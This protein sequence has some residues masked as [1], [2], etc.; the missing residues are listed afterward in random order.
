M[1][2][3]ATQ[4][5]PATMPAPMPTPPPQTPSAL[6]DSLN[7]TLYNAPELGASPGLAVGV[8][9][10]GGDPTLRA[11]VI[12][13]AA[14]ATSDT[15]AAVAVNNSSGGVLGSALNWLGNSVTHAVGDVAHVAKTAF[16][17]VAKPAM[18]L[19]NAPLN[20]VQ[21]EY[22]YLHD[23]EASHGML[24][25]VAEGIGIAAVS[26][27]VGVAT[28]GAGLGALS[29]AGGAG[30][31]M[32]AAGSLAGQAFYKDSWDRTTNGATYTDPH[33]HQPVSL[34]R[35]IASVLG[36][37]PGTEV[38][39][40]TSGAIDGI[41]DMGVNIPGLGILRDVHS[42][43][44]AGGALGKVFQGYG[45]MDGEKVQHAFDEG[46]SVGLTSPFKRAMQDVAGKNAAE[47]VASPY[48]SKLP[49]VIVN[50]LA[51]ASTAEEA[52][53]V[54]KDAGTAQE[55]AFVDRLPT[56]S[57]TRAYVSQ[58]LREAA[59]N[60]SMD[61][62]LGQN[63]IVGPGRWFHRLSPIA[64]SLDE[65][66][67]ASMEELDPMSSDAVKAVYQT[68]LYT[69]NRRTALDIAN[70]FNDMPEV[71]QRVIAWRNLQMRTLMN[72][73]DMRMTGVVGNEAEQ[74]HTLLKN[75]FTDPTQ[76]DRAMKELNGF[77]DQGMFGKDAIYG[78][79]D[80][81]KNVSLIR[82]RASGTW[83]Y[84]AAVTD[85]QTGSVSM[86]DL[87]QARRVGRALHN[88]DSIFSAADKAD[89]ATVVGKLR[90]QIAAGDYAGRIDDIGYR[91]I[92]Q[93]IFK[94]LVLLTPSYAMHI[95]LAEMIPNALR[96]GVVH[97]AKDALAVNAAKLGI[98]EGDLH[99]SDEALAK[100]TANRDSSLVK[101]PDAVAGLAWRMVTRS[102]D[103]LPDRITNNLTERLQYAVRYIE[104]QGGE[105]I[106]PALQSGHSLSDIT[107]NR[108]ETATRVLR[109]AVDRSPMS[110]DGTYIP[111][112][113]THKNF[114]D[115]WGK[116]LNAH[117]IKDAGSQHAAGILLSE[118]HAGKNLAEAS[119]TAARMTADWIRRKAIDDPVWDQ[120]YIRNNEDM[121]SFAPGIDRP[122]EWDAA[123]EFAEV[124]V[125]ALR[126]I[127]RGQDGTIHEALLE[128]V[129]E[130][131]PVTHY[132]LDAIDPAQRPR[133]VPGTEMIPSG[134]SRIQRI[135]NVGFVK[136]LNPMVNFLSRQSFA[137]EEY[138]TQMKQMES[139]VDK[140][141]VTA[142][143]ADVLAR[144]KAAV[145]GVRFIHNLTDRTQWT[146]TMR[147]WAPFFFAQEQAY[148]RMGRLLAEDPVAFR[149]YQLMIANVG[150][151]GQVFSQPGGSPYFVMPHTGWFNTG[152]RVLGALSVLQ[153]PLV[154]SSPVGLG[155]NLNASS[156]IFPLSAGARPDL[157]PLVGIPTQ[158][159]ANFFAEHA[160]PVLASQITG[161][162]NIALGATASS[163]V[164][165][166]FVP[167][168][169]LDRLLTAAVPAFNERSF[170]SAFMQTLQTLDFQG[171]IPPA[172][173]SPWVMQAFLD[174]WRNQT[175]IMYAAKALV[176]A[177]TPVSP[178]IVVQ[179][180]GLPAELTA[181]IVKAGSVTNGITEFLAK[182]PDAT[183]YTVYQSTNP[184]GVSVP[185]SVAAEDWINANMALIKKYPNAA[186]TLMPPLTNTTYNA[187]VYN[188]QIA[189]GLRTK[190]FP[191]S[192][193]PNGELSGYL[194]QLY[195]AAGNSIVLDKW[196]PVYKQQLAGLSGSQKYNAEQAWQV[197]LANYAKQN[198]V[199]GQ[200]WNSNQKAPHRSAAITQMQSMFAAGDAP[201]TPLSTKVAGL[202]QDYKVYEQ[203]ITTGQQDSFAGTTQSTL[204][205][206]W[207]SYLDGVATDNPE[208]KPVINALFLTLPTPAAVPSA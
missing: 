166:Q 191:G 27:G 53:Q 82:D 10:S 167:N 96:V 139:A 199:W 52:M 173:S 35:D 170:D 184:T 58:P 30:L 42:V 37:K 86:I 93:G 66:G 54:F 116:F 141:I 159:I 194:S 192:V 125:A 188:E 200:W 17:D 107:G 108:E 22:R 103:V 156:V 128:H 123:R 175:R 203:Q 41:F 105:T 138:Y 187:T 40:I 121:T 180:F 32:M 51:R 68:A 122:A 126:G 111:Y 70:A 99:L 165:S 133:L 147:N 104:G 202:L 201:K 163:S 168:T 2:D 81:G 18:T 1:T 160:G 26:V 113:N 179:N 183:P 112:A 6:A 196:Y 21:H 47:I 39:K 90:S 49:P 57:R 174:K 64:T 15:K 177:L 132:E 205:A 87:G 154:G 157:G 20:L 84:S 164:W 45:V 13:R 117:T 124:K 43:A 8:A 145:H 161:A 33:T 24:A 120:K 182:H 55:L 190:W 208:L 146:V 60:V 72:L 127:T 162:E 193:L 63:A 158:V 134:D 85:S 76:A 7:K 31:G 151:V 74:A 98:R 176:G 155:W 204:N 185:S 148:R 48:L 59:G 118:L 186:L 80:Q 119:S 9:T 153:N 4:P 95:S 56:L 189:Q 143:Q 71:Q 97:L 83:T 169:I 91:A 106:D 29:L 140:G 89:A 46:A 101:L 14:T 34:G 50:R 88:A 38:F 77:L 62:T 5:T 73:G 11:P 102:M 206:N 131:R 115:T 44:G 195:V 109:Q 28:G 65:A 137:F 94:P 152:A 198:P 79:D 3:S 172:N 16:Q 69:E 75:A 171:Q 67:K 61:S 129:A 92:T 19:L 135:A 36:I 207:Q 12:A 149:K 110:T 144:T 114:V 178:E 197:S 142:D 136:V 100:F 23:V 78:Y 181:D 25:A 130:G 150:N